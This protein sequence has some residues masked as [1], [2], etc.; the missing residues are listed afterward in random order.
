MTNKTATEIPGTA[1]TRPGP[2][3]VVTRGLSL[4]GV[5]IALIAIAAIAQPRFLLIENLR[6]GIVVSAAI[7]LIVA[8]GQ[9]LVIITRNIDLSVA[10]ILGFSAYVG[11]SLARELPD[12]PIVVS[13]LAGLGLGLVL[14][15]VNGL[16]VVVGRVPAI[17]ATLGTLFIFRGVMALFAKGNPIAAGELAPD[18]IGFPTQIVL[19]LP[20]IAILA[21]LVVLGGGYFLHRTR[22][23][24]GMYAIG[25]NADA[26]RVL[27]IS[28]SRHTF[29]AFLVSGGL[30]GLAGVIW[31]MRYA[32]A[33]SGTASG[34]ELAV[35]AAVVVGGVT[36]FG[37]SG[38]I[39]GVV[40]GGLL[41]VTARNVLN[42]LGISGY[43]IQAV[44][45]ATI[46]AAIV[47]DAAIARRLARTGTREAGG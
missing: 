10:S 7:L 25:S 42:I 36:V 3:L 11:G 23:G 43:W 8:T 9:A 13:L 2:D 45:G 35:I 39:F 44:Y 12:L 33:D 37:G 14:G 18:F 29:L 32:G 26:A 28:V 21:I 34:Y 27:G 19:G 38:S 41:L 47:T 20:V 30:S 46:V 15:S 1:T 6:D 16:L 40:I 24:R 17:V 5:L 4:L 31:V 22:V